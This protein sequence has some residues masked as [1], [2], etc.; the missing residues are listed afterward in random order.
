MI[1]QVSQKTIGRLSLYRRLLN[2]LA[3]EGV[4]NVYSHQ[5]ASMAGGTAAQ[6]RRDLMSIGYSG[7]PT[8]GY[9]VQELIKSIRGFLDSPQVQGVALVGIGNLGRAIM[10]YFTGRRPNLSIVA[11]FDKDPHKAN[12]IVHGCRCYGMDDLARV[13]REQDIHVGAITVPAAE[14]Q[15]VAN[16]LVREG[17][18]GIVNFAPAALR[19]PPDVYVE[20]IDMSMSLEKVAYFARQGL[21]GKEVQQ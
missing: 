3:V 15:D 1:S 19:V 5:L 9:E 11:A 18:R 2:E 12:R 20:D 10:A 14:A 4:R 13:I 8:R 17:V 7:S 6:V 16:K 21:V